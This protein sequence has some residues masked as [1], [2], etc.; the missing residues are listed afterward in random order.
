MDSVQTFGLRVWSAAGRA[1]MVK[2]A[3]KRWAKVRKEAK[4]VKRSNSDAT[5]LRGGT[6]CRQDLDSRDHYALAALD[7]GRRLSYEI[8]EVVAMHFCLYA[9]APANGRFRA[10][11][12]TELPAASAKSFCRLSARYAS[13]TSAGITGHTS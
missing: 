1:A 8:A 5:I 2:V 4:N 6:S 10:V 13:S 12:V 11:H 9:C 7:D 3:K